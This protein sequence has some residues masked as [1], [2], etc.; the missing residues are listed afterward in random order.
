MAIFHCSIKVIKRSVGRSAVAAAAYRSGACMKNEW[1]GMTHDYTRKGGV[2]HTEILLPESAST[3]FADRSVLWNSIEQIEKSKDAQLAREIELALP[4]ELSRTEQIKLARAYVQDTFVASGMCADF[5]IHDKDGG[6]PH[7][8]ILLTMRPLDANGEWGAKCRKEYLLDG[9][10]QRIPDGHGNYKSRR[11]DTTDW[12]DKAKAEQWRQAWADYA[13]RAL[14]RGNHTERIDHRSYERQGVEQIPTVHMGVAATRMER[15]GVHTEKGDVNREVVAQ[16]RLLKEIRARITRLYNWSKELP[17]QEDKP[18]VLALLQQAQNTQPT[19]RYGKVK[20]LKES[21]ALF[22]FLQ[23]N[24]I[25]S[26]DEL[27]GKITSLQREYYDLRGEIVSTEKQIA[28]L[29]ERLAMARQYRENRNPPNESQ[30]ILYESAAR[31]VS[32]LKTSGVEIAPK[33]WK[34]EADKLT[35]RKDTLY[36]EMRS[37]RQNIQAVEKLRKAA[38]QIS[39]AQGRKDK[40]QER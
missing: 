27:H 11:A 12:N 25:A 19:T 37:M 1:D 21:A 17:S 39:K 26:M 10:G 14:E 6:N 32:E 16:N 8:H 34:A 28:A 13:N 36:Q 18:S 30:R 9:H 22:N 35:L 38:E 31:Y 40:E 33:A 15:R 3:D 2:V 20:A 5:A 23:E 7:A 29:Q 24:G 4:A